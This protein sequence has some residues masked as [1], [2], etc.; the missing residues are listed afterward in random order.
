MPRSSITNYIDFVTRQI[1]GLLQS[2]TVSSEV[3]SISYL[4]ELYKC[5][6]SCLRDAAIDYAT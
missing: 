4:K 1:S 3:A 5:R 6:I 2:S